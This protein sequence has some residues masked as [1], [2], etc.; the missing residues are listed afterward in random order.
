M[1]D[2]QPPEYGDPI[3]APFWAAAREHRLVLQRCT[4]CSQAQFY[5]R[6]YCI[7][8]QGDVAWVDAS[9][10]ATVHSQTT[11]ELQMLPDVP[12]PY[13]V[14]VVQLDEGPRMTTRIVDGETTIGD[15]VTVTWQDRPD[16]P[17]LPLF[18][19]LS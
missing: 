2:S 11:V 15:R 19:P 4:S 14:A 13:V 1:T 17:P 16:A 18:A 12:P 3:S 9:G 8:C 5:P 10:L 6:P 7:A